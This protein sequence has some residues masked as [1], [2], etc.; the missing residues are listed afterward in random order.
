MASFSAGIRKEI[1][2]GGPNKQKCR[3]WT[4]EHAPAVKRG[5]AILP[6]HFDSRWFVF[7]CLWRHLHFLHGCFY[8]TVWTRLS[9]KTSFRKVSSEKKENIMC[10]NLQGYFKFLKQ[11]LS[12]RL[13]FLGV[14]SVRFTNLRFKIPKRA[15]I[16][17]PS[18]LGPRNGLKSSRKLF[19]LSLRT[20][21]SA[22]NI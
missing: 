21:K 18:S 1:S 13:R 22:L 15:N 19:F 16:K 17:K 10:S 12:V 8:C 6:R 7:K 3:H 4:L 9:W 11:M 20:V 14:L 2:E 5:C